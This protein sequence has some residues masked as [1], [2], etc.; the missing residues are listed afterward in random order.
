MQNQK[1]NQVSID[2]S[3]LPDLNS[4]EQTFVEA[5]GQGSNNI[6]AYKKAYGATGYSSAALKVRACRKAA[7]SKI[8]SHLNALRSVG[9][10]T[11]ALTIQNRLEEEQAF[12]KRCEL[13]GNMGAAGGAYDRINKL[14]GFYVEKFADVS[15]DDPMAALRE[16]ATLDPDIAQRLASQHN[17]E[18]PNE[19]QAKPH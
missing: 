18:W 12:A 9:F 2:V 13:A 19:P 15:K 16:L 6:E 8:Q 5:L 14:M 11:T 4:E 17:I 3:E 10:A 1:T 7:E